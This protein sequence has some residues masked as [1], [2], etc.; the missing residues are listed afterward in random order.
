MPKY[1]GLSTMLIHSEQEAAEAEAACSSARGRSQDHRESSP[2]SSA[3]ITANCTLGAFQ[4]E[5]GAPQ[6]DRNAV[7][8]EPVAAVAG[9]E[10]SSSPQD[11]GD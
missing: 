2:F 10:Y 4:R 7:P 5:Q 8:K 6:I 9:G 11:P 1:Y 3:F